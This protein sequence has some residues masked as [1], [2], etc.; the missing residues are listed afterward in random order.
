MRPKHAKGYALSHSQLEIYL[1]AGMCGIYIPFPS[2]LWKASLKV[3]CL[4]I[5][6]VAANRIPACS[7]V[8][9]SAVC[10]IFWRTTFDT[11]K[12]KGYQTLF[13]LTARVIAMML[14]KTD[15]EVQICLLTSLYSTVFPTDQ[16]F[17][18]WIQ[19]KDIFFSGINTYGEILS[20]LNWCKSAPTAV[21]SD[22]L[23]WD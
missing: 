1:Y 21:K 22:H 15:R 17:D 6:L 2:F 9:E 20:L 11:F 23:P 3:R 4:H 5:P 16:C 14:N 19:K 8:L 10:V 18:G 12:L 13:L 7:L